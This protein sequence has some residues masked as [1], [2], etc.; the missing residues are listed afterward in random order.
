MAFK[1]TLKE[2]FHIIYHTWTVEY[3]SRWFQSTFKT[4]DCWIKGIHLV[5]TIRI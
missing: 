1:Q 5:G 2:D 4:T 3:E